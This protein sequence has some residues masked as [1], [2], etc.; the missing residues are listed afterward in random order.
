[1]RSV[2]MIA[3]EVTICD[4][5]L[6]LDALAS[7][8]YGLR[9]VSLSNLPRAFRVRSNRQPVGELQAVVPNP[10]L[11]EPAKRPK[12]E[13]AELLRNVLCHHHA[14][15]AE[16]PSC[17]AAYDTDHLS[18]DCALAVALPCCSRQRG[19]DLFWR[20]YWKEDL[21]PNQHMMC[22]VPPQRLKGFVRPFS[23]DFPQNRLDT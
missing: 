9:F 20:G 2:S 18:C 7:W 4:F 12:C 16:L 22:L 21:L 8:D 5:K 1:M 15:L 14:L 19:V 17:C 10:S 6:A 13:I 3:L 11:Q 23:A